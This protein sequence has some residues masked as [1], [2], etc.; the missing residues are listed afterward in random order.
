[1]T[2]GTYV[3]PKQR[4]RRTKDLMTRARDNLRQYRA[5]FSITDGLVGLGKFSHRNNANV[6][7]WLATRNDQPRLS[8][9]ERGIRT[10]GV[11]KLPDKLRDQLA[12]RLTNP[13]EEASISA[14]SEIH[15]A[16]NLSR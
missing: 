15:I 8:E 13:R 3:A 11:A 4:R 6:L 14:I 9:V 7:F 2:T 12:S 16:Y 10:L 1:M 5:V